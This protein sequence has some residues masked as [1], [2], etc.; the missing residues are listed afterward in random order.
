M[1]PPDSKE[2]GHPA[3][4]VAKYRKT[5]RLL[6]IQVWLD[7]WHPSRYLAFGIRPDI[8]IRQNNSPDIRPF[9]YPVQP[10]GKTAVPLEAAGPCLVVHE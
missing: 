4:N 9:H 1:Y 5:C 10:Y 2:A 8:G 7:I 3:N 6:G